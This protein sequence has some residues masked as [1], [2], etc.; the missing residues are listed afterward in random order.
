MIHNAIQ[1]AYDN[2]EQVGFMWGIA[3]GL[4]LAVMVKAAKIIM[5]DK[6]QSN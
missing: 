5:K 1:N 2:G 4:F 3:C 6:E